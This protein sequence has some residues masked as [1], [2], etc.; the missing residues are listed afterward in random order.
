MANVLTAIRLLLVIPFAVLMARG[1]AR[2]AALAAVAL[3]VAIATDLLDGPIAR[4]GG[5]ASAAGAVFDHT[6]DFLFVAAGLAGGAVRGAFPWILP[7]F[8]TS[9]FVQYVVDSYWVHRHRTLRTSR[10]GRYNGILYFTPPGVDIVVRLGLRSLQPLLTALVWVLVVS[11]VV[12]MG[13]RLWAVTA[14]SRRAPGSPAGQT[15]DPPPR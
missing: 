9:A 3:A 1:D 2:A 13:E 11:T 7:I 4:W 14:S 6:S 15:G 8:V 12:S 10:L 5:T